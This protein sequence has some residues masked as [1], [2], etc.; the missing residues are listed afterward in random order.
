MASTVSSISPMQASIEA[1]ADNLLFEQGRLL[2]PP[3]TC[4]STLLKQILVQFTNTYA[5]PDGSHALLS[6]PSSLDR[7]LNSIFDTSC[8]AFVTEKEFRIEAGLDDHDKVTLFVQAVAGMAMVFERLLRAC[9]SSSAAFA[10]SGSGDLTTSLLSR[11]LQ[12]FAESEQRRTM[13]DR[14]GATSLLS[15]CYT[16]DEL[17]SFVVAMVED[18]DRASQQGGSS[19]LSLNAAGEDLSSDSVAW[20]SGRSCKNMGLPWGFTIMALN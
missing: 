10:N 14:I 9:S 15:H 1:A 18:P 6:Q 19:L 11:E 8:L 4:L 13:L 5:L 16:K 7:I 12:L 3:E 2:V 17:V 20:V